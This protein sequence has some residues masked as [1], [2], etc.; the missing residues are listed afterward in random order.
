[1]RIAIMGAGLSGLSCA[2]MLEKHGISADIFEKRSRVGDRFVNGEA[3]MSFLTKP[4]DDVVR[5]LSEEFHLYVKPASAI[6]CLTF[7]SGRQK[8]VIEA[9]SG[10]ITL[11]GR[12]RH[13]L[14]Q[15]LAEQVSSPVHYHSERTY[16]SL[17]QDYTHVILATGDASYAANL[18][19]FQEYLSVSLKGAI[20][21]GNFERDHVRIWL[22]NNI[23][24]QGYAYLLP[25]SST[26]A[27]LVMAYPDT[28]AGS[29][30]Q[31]EKRWQL[32]LEAASQALQQ[33]LPINDQFQ[34]KNYK[35]GMCCSPRIGNTFFTGNC[36]GSIMPF[37]GFGQ[38]ESILTGIYAAFDL[39]GYGRYEEFTKPLRKSFHDSMVLRQGME[40]L[41]NDGFSFIVKQLNTSVG[42]RLFSSN[43]N[44]MRAGSM[45]LRPFTGERMRR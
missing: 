38:L 35:I 23:A 39:C 15:Q 30:E 5:Y 27:N 7:Y 28:S 11:R 13:A 22:D 10:F 32:L 26:K 37:L 8:A 12:H 19:N 16:E 21:E 34:I 18:R 44:V 2:L 36:F 33:S 6:S 3:F 25:I 45:L 1:M 24:P 42:K 20:I 14:E 4:I 43:V 9:H 29:K 31:T 41:N 17:Q 40:T